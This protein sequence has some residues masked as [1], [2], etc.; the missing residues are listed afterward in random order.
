MESTSADESL[1]PLL[2]YAM[3]IHSKTQIPVWQL[4]V[5]IIERIQHM[6]ALFSLQATE[7]ATKS[8]V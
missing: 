4:R 2:H 6:T 8:H 1:L 5:L 3:S 7:T